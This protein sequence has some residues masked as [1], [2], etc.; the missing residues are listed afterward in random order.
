MLQKSPFPNEI[1]KTPDQFFLFVINADQLHIT[2]IKLQ[3]ALAVEHASQT[4]CKLEIG[5]GFRLIDFPDLHK[6]TRAYY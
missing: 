3:P 5:V 4:F 6:K 1:M 2:A